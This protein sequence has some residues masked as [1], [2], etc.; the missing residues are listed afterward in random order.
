MF[1][2]GSSTRKWVF[3]TMGTDAASEAC[4]VFLET[5]RTV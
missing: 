3:K 4:G 5:A 1:I 2:A